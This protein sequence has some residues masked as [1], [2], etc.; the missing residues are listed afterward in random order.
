MFFS[1]LSRLSRQPLFVE[2]VAKA[3]GLMKRQLRALTGDNI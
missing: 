1:L 2:V 3:Y